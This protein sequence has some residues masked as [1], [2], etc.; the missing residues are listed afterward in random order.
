[1]MTDF[2]SV[3]IGLEAAQTL[4]FSDKVEFFQFLSRKSLPLR[5]VGPVAVKLA[6]LLPLGP[7][8]IVQ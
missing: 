6:L 2:Q 3:C 1:M 7:Q 5:E 4:V 8:Q